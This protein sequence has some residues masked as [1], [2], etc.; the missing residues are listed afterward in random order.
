LFI[1]GKYWKYWEKGSPNAYIA[2]AL[3]VPLFTTFMQR[4]PAAKH[5]AVSEWLDFTRGLVPPTESH[6]M[7]MHLGEGCGLCHELK[8]FCALL[9]RICARMSDAAVPDWVVIKAKAV[10]P[11]AAR[12]KPKKVLLLP[13]ELVFESVAPLAAASLRSTDEAGWEALYR[14]DGYSL[15]L[16]AETN[17]AAHTTALVGQVCSSAA[18]PPVLDGLPVL[19]KSGNTVI[20]EAQS[21]RFGEFQLEYRHKSRVVLYIPVEGQSKCFRIA[22]KPFGSR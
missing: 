18:P 10:C 12:P 21:N 3:G 4:T 15:H 22:L 20:A 16:R 1:L 19:L 9:S 7:T 8:N 11:I 2:Q 5:Y 13:T 6:R 17:P 14:A